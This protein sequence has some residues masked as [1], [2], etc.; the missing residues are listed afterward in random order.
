MTI[1][2]IQ[3]QATFNVAINVP[4]IIEST[5]FEVFSPYSNTVLFSLPATFVESNDRYSLFTVAIPTDFWDNH[6]NGMYTYNVYLGAE[7]LDSGSFKLITKPGGDM[8]T[9]PHVSNNENREAQVVFRS[10]Y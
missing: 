3:N 6:Y 8:G 2:I 9:V 7:T 1:K 10:N 4:N 5:Q